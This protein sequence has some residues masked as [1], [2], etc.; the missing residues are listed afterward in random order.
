M[1]LRRLRSAC[2]VC[3]VACAIVREILFEGLRRQQVVFMSCRVGVCW[4]TWKECGCSSPTTRRE[5]RK[6]INPGTVSE[7]SSMCQMVPFASRASGSFNGCP[8]SSPRRAR[9]I[10]VDSPVRGDTIPRG[11]A[12]LVSFPSGMHLFR[13]FFP[14]REYY[15]AHHVQCWEKMVVPCFVTSNSFIARAYARCAEGEILARVCRGVQATSCT[16]T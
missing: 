13:F 1:T 4:K 2:L 11:G 6:P 9:L 14:N 8:P 5:K 10:Y 16:G 12:S 3:G 15:T 7:E